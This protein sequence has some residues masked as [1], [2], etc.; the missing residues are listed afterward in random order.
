MRHVLKSRSEA[1]SVKASHQEQLP[2]ENPHCVLIV[3]LAGVA[4]G[5]TKRNRSPY[6]H[7]CSTN[8]V[9]EIGHSLCPFPIR[10]E[11]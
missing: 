2:G 5:F 8:K 4:P 3:E 1:G 9:Q 11:F 7:L 6:H 10:W